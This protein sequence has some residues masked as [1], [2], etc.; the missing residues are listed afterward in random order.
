MHPFRP[1]EPRP[2]ARATRLML[3]QKLGSSLP[4][5]LPH[6]PGRWQRHY[7]EGRRLSP[8]IRVWRTLC[9]SMRPCCW[10][11]VTLQG[12]QQRARMP[13]TNSEVQSSHESAHKPRRR[14][15]RKDGAHQDGTCAPSNNGAKRPCVCCLLCR[16]TTVL[17]LLRVCHKLSNSSPRCWCA[18]SAQ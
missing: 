17:L 11:T 1:D 14:D 9:H 10:H 2:A 15:A 4:T 7:G 3:R 18:C 13:R 12:R 8:P 5:C 6:D 16:N